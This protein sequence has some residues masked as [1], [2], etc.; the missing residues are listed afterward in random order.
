MRLNLS[1]CNIGGRYDLPRCRFGRLRFGRI[2]FALPIRR[3]Q[4]PLSLNLQAPFF[5]ALEPLEPIEMPGCFVEAASV[6]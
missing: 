6:P 1:S 4:I 3:E 5:G 2:R